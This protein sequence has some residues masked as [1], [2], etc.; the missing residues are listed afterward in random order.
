MSLERRGAVWAALMGTVAA[1]IAVV[2]LAAQFADDP[3]VLRGFGLGVG[4][5]GLALSLG[6]VG[7]LFLSDRDV[8]DPYLYPSVVA[9]ASVLVL[10]AT[11]A[12][13]TGARPPV[14]ALALVC[15][16]VLMVVGYTLVFVSQL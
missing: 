6:M 2:L 3:S 12:G 1:G 7:W 4:A 11:D 9:S 16:A 10:V 5:V 14:L 8:E 13:A 15:A